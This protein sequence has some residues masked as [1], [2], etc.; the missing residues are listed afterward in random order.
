[1]TGEINADISAGQG[2]ADSNLN[3]GG[4]IRETHTGGGAA[5]DGNAHTRD[6]TGRDSKQ[7]NISQ[8]NNDAL[9]V[10]LARLEIFDH[11]FE[12]FNARLGELI[13]MRRDMDDIKVSV[14]RVLE[15][16]PRMRQEI[17][18]MEQK[19]SFHVTLLWLVIGMLVVAIALIWLRG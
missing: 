15:I 9:A 6:F 19:F 16:E 12:I 7:V 8:L 11:R 13:G 4:T 17:S 18:S 10:V 3:V 5:V 2:V 1:M 14:Y